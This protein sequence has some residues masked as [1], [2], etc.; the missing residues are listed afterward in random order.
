MGYSR[1]IDEAAFDVHLPATN[2]FAERAQ[3]L[4]DHPFDSPARRRSSIEFTAAVPD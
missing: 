3:R 1:W 2:A 4:I